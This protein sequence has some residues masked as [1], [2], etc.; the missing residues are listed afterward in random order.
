MHVFF[1]DWIDNKLK[2]DPN[3][4]DGIE[5]IHIPTEKIWKPDILLGI[6]L[7]LNQL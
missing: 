3:L 1:Q 2:W 6:L 4:Y 5:F 7:F